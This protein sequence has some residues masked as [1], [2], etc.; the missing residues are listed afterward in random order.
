MGSAPGGSSPEVVAGAFALL[1]LARG[2]PRRNG[3]RLRQGVC[4][5]RL[6][7]CDTSDLEPNYEKLAIYADSTNTPSHMVRQ[8]SSGHWTSKL[9]ELEDIQHLTLDQLSGSDYGRVVQILKRK[10]PT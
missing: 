3:C 1:L 5:P 4:P 9:G 6:T 8:L 10:R 2:A 7:V